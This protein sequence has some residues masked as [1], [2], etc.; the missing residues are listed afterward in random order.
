MSIGNGCFQSLNV[1]ASVIPGTV[2][3]SPRSPANMPSIGRMPRTSNVNSSS[4]SS[5]FEP[6]L[7]YF[8]RICAWRSSAEIPKSWASQSQSNTPFFPSGG[9]CGSIGPNGAAKFDGSGTPAT[10]EYIENFFPVSSPTR[11]IS[12]VRYASTGEVG[13]FS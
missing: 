9:D 12:L 10:I 3:I 2:G 6:T 7:W 8:T 1:F 5:P 4:G 11:L 13:S